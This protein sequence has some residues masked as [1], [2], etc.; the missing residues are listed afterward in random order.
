MLSTKKRIHAEADVWQFRH[1]APVPTVAIRR[2]VSHCAALCLPEKI[3]W[4]DGSAGERDLLRER[5]QLNEGF[6]VGMAA[7]M[8]QACIEVEPVDE[9]V[10]EAKKLEDLSAIFRGCMRG[11]TMY[12]VPFVTRPVNGSLGVRGLQVTDS[13]A[14]AAD[15]EEA[16]ISGEPAWVALSRKEPALF[17]VHTE[18]RHAVKAVR[19]W[20][21]P[22]ERAVWALGPGFDTVAVV[23][24]L[25][26]GGRWS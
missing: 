6:R 9:E 2:W 20:S 12:V 4:C 24:A 11:R 8:S 1:T 21:F 3:Y 22:E 14:V 10:G 15:M 23:G 16:N 17:C 5:A 18:G 25:Q 19:V 7:F 26:F 13:P